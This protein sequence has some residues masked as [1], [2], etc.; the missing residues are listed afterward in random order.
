MGWQV[1]AGNI[2]G[3]SVETAELA[4]NSVTMSKLLAGLKLISTQAA[5]SDTSISFSSLTAHNLFVLIVEGTPD[6]SGADCFVSVQINGLTDAHHDWTS[7][8]NNGVS[9][10][11][12]DTSVRIGGGLKAMPV[13]ILATITGAGTDHHKIACMSSNYNNAGQKIINVGGIKTNDT[14][15]VSQIDVLFSAAFTGSVSLYYVVEA[16]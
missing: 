9:H 6:G 15:A 3:S 1:S 14:A 10:T 2:L 8:V 16:E 5:S 11:T 13:S 4:A 7:L 12:G